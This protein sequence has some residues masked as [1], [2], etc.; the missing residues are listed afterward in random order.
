MNR[1]LES[2]IIWI[3]A[4][5]FNFL[6]IIIEILAVYYMAL[7]I[8]DRREKNKL[9]EIERMNAKKERLKEELTN[10]R[11]QEREG[12]DDSKYLPYETEFHELENEEIAA[13]GYKIELEIR[14]PLALEKYMVNVGNGIVIG[15]ADDCS[16]SLSD[17]DVAYHHCR[18]GQD[19]A[20]LYIKRLDES[21]ITVIE[22]GRN[23]FKLQ[24]APVR[25]NEKDRINLGG[26]LISIKKVK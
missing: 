9:D 2:L 12:N 10:P 4:N 18:I 20:G 7:Q 19:E 8:I 17:L 14:G 13:P 15:S 3:E 6:L 22:R 26:S 25:L 16:I 21:Y 5:P 11:W 1:L 23:F 24:D